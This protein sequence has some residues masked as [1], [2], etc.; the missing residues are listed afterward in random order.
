MAK[1]K[2]DWLTHGDA[3]WS[4]L[5]D[6]Y[7]TPI[8]YFLARHLP[9]F[10]WIFFQGVVLAFEAGSPL[11]F[12]LRWTR[13][14]A[15]V[16]GLGMHLFIGLCFGPVVWFALLMMSLLI[17]SFAPAAWIE[18]AFDVVGGL[19]GRLRRSRA[20]PADGAKA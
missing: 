1:A 19:P 8:A 16:V 9:A 15:L 3:V 6:S 5:H 20:A 11:W 13:L 14:P 12:S 4:H 2:G 7:Q 18:R 17:G 10:S